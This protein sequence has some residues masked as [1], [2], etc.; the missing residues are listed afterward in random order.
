MHVRVSFPHCVWLYICFWVP[1][2][3]CIASVRVYFRGYIWVDMWTVHDSVWCVSARVCVKVCV[4]ILSQVSGTGSTSTTGGLYVSTADAEL[5]VSG[6]GTITGAVGIAGDT[7]AT[8][9]V[10]ISTGPFQLSGSTT[11]SV[12]KPV[13]LGSPV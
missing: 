1:V 2:F 8:G 10:S 6:G 7:T 5:S 11:V 4:L 9:T 13:N 3:G 12:K